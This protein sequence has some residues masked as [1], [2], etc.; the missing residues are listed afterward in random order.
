MATAT[1]TLTITLTEKGDDLDVAIEFD[2]PFDTEDP[3]EVHL[4]ALMAVEA[5]AKEVG[6]IDDVRVGK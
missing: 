1:I 5:L 6:C 2:P 4:D 3:N